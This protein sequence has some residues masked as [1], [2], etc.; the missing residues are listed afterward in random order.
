[1]FA[2]FLVVQ[3]VGDTRPNDDGWG[4]FDMLWPEGVKIQVKSSAYLQS[5]SQ[6]NPSRIVFSG[7]MR[8]T[9]SAETGR[10]KTREVRADVFVF[11]VHTCQSPDAYDPLDLDAWGF[12]VLSGSTIREI[13]Q[14]SMNL[15]RVRAF[16]GDPIKWSQLRTTILQKANQ[17]EME[18][19]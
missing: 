7:L 2:Q 15:N 4:D 8:Q 1:M 11:A 12:Y 19:R 9:W 17:H 3:A 16:A 18:I 10:S 5:W 13:G 6:E 14:R